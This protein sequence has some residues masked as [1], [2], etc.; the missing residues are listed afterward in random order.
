MDMIKFGINKPDPTAVQKRNQNSGRG[1][2]PKAAGTAEYKNSV[3]DT[4]TIRSG[5]APAS[6]DSQFIQMVKKHLLSEIG[7]GAS[8]YKLNDLRCQVAL[9]QY[10]VNISEIVRKMTLESEI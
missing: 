1:A 7:A 3:Q 2:M 10:D 8:E 4:I 5:G 9:G 6:S